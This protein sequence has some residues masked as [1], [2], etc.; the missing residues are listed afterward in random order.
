MVVE[1]SGATVSSD[2]ILLLFSTLKEC[3]SGE[4]SPSYVEE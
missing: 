2:W 4:V 3:S 1:F